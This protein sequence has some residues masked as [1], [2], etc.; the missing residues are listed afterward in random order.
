MPTLTPRL[1]SALAL[2]LGAALPLAAQTHD[3][4]A[5]PAS[6]ASQASQAGEAA[7]AA[8]MTAGEVRRVDAANHRITLRHGEI[9]N[10]DMPPMTMV[11]KVEPGVSLDGLKAGDQIHFQARQEGGSLVVTEIQR[12]P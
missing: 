8:A 6:P 9:K 11:F 3:H 1:L 7:S 12:A 5:S 10:L 4:A 2:T